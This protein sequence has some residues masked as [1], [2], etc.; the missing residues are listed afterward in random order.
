[1]EIWNKKKERQQEW[2]AIGFPWYYFENYRPNRV[3]LWVLGPCLPGGLFFFF[4]VFLYILGVPY[5]ATFIF[6]LLNVTL[7]F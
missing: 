1:M 5:S 7:K 2:Q 6:Y 4:L 3:S